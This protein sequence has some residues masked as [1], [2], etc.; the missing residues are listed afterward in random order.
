MT[1]IRYAA[2]KALETKLKTILTTNGYNYDLGENV[3]IGVPKLD[4]KFTEYLVIWP[5][6]DDIDD[7]GFYGRWLMV[8]PVKIEAVK[9]ISKEVDDIE[10]ISQKMLSDITKCLY[11]PNVTGIDNSNIQYAGGGIESYPKPGETVVGVVANYEISYQT[12]AGD[13]TSS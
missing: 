7:I 6:V 3:F 13:L 4:P 1:T 2:I 10:L 11:N 12:E 5:G 8:M 9:E